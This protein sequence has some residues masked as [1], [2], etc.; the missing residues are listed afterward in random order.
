[1][2][3]PFDETDA[4]SGRP[5]DGVPV[6]RYLARETLLRLLKDGYYEGD[7]W[8]EVYRYLAKPYDR[9][10]WS[11][12]AALAQ[13]II[14]L[15]TAL[16]EWPGPSGFEDDWVPLRKMRRKW[17]SLP[18]DFSGALEGDKLMREYESIEA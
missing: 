13:R 18:Q 6:P 3:E 2:A 12:V 7:G 8:V 5:M 1:M 14:D 17:G 10:G 11:D 15:A 9:I 4:D 16:G